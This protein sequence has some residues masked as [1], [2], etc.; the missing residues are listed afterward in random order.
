MKIAAYVMSL[1]LFV[2]RLI[3]L[4]SSWATG[5]N[6]ARHGQPSTLNQRNNI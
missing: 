1:F 2:P 3:N 5:N 4:P 6:P